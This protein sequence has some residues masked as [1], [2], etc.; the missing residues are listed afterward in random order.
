MKKFLSQAWWFMPVIPA[1]GRHRKDTSLRLPSEFQ[2]SLGYIERPSLKKNQEIF[3][4][5]RV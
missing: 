2:A 1:F 3:I 4:L 5:L